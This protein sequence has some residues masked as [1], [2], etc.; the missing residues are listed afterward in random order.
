MKKIKRR[1]TTSEIRKT[2]ILEAATQLALK[3]GYHKITR[4]RI[5]KTAKTSS[6]LISHYFKSMDNLRQSL[7]QRA[8]ETE[9]C[10]IIA[11]GLTVGDKQALKI[12]KDLKQKVLAFL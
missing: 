11:Q 6:A 12:S 2:E 8:I 3:F 9:N 10:T 7:M 1:R 4:D 5:A